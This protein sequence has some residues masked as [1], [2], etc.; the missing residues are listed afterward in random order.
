MIV[1]GGTDIKQSGTADYAITKQ[2]QATTLRTVFRSG[3]LIR[4]VKLDT[5]Q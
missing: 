3:Y 1:K 4:G 5:Y 2:T